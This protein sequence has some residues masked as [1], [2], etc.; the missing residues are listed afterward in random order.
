VLVTNGDGT[1]SWE[2]ISI[3]IQEVTSSNDMVD[4][5]LFYRYKGS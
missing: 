1:T 4:I 2:N 3:K 5:N